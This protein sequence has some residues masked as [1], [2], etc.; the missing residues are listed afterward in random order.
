MSAAEFVSRNSE[1]TPRKRKGIKLHLPDAKWPVM[2]R[3][4]RSKLPEELSGRMFF[5]TDEAMNTLAS[6]PCG[7]NRE[8]AIQIGG[9]I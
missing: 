4:R 9:A 8:A 6:A 7:D 5:T 2:A 3:L 1:P